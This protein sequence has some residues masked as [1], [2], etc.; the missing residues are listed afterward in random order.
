MSQTIAIG[1][2]HAGFPYKNSIIRSLK[3]RGFEVL[4]FGTSSP[5]SVDTID[6]NKYLCASGG[7]VGYLRCYMFALRGRA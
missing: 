4:D 5:D 7:F 2:D 6:C 3:K 1:C